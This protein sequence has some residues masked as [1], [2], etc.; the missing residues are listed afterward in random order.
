MPPVNSIKQLCVKTPLVKCEIILH[1][2]YVLSYLPQVFCCKTTKM[3][4]FIPS[5]SYYMYYLSMIVLPLLRNRPFRDVLPHQYNVHQGCSSVVMSVTSK[6][7]HTIWMHVGFA[8]E[9]K[10]VCSWVWNRG[11]HCSVDQSAVISFKPFL[12]PF[13]S[14]AYSAFIW[15]TSKTKPGKTETGI[16]QFS[17]YPLVFK[18]ANIWHANNSERFKWSTTFAS[19]LCITLLD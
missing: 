6:K 7:S 18:N 19:I 12:S 15:I 4:I 5:K 14:M 3:I 10:C 2:Y 11:V 13:C 16:S 8:F 1:M 9:C 17:F